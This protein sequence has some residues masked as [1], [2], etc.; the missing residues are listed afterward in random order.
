MKNK[1]AKKNFNKIPKPLLRSRSLNPIKEKKAVFFAV[2]KAG[3][4]SKQL[5]HFFC[6]LCLL[7]HQ[8]KKQAELCI[9]NRA[10]SLITKRRPLMK[11]KEREP[12]C[13]GER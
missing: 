6:F 3:Y 9:L 5:F 2:K 1:D 13:Y 12:F 7:H 4:F 10:Q 11:K 8:K